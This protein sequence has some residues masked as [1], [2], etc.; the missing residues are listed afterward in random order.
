MFFWYFFNRGGNFAKDELES[1]A[2]DSELPLEITIVPCLITVG[3]P[4][5]LRSAVDLFTSMGRSVYLKYS[6]G[7]NGNK[8][9]RCN[10]FILIP[11]L[12]KKEI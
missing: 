1:I 4:K 8:C 11:R 12:K 3:P 9:S 2:V 6:L 10:C 7:S 5:L